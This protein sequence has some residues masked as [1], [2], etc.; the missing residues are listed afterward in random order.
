MRRI[1]TITVAATALIAVC[2]TSTASAVDVG[3][4]STSCVSGKICFFGGGVGTDPSAST[5]TADENFTDNG[6]Y[7]SGTTFVRSVN[8]GGQ[9]WKNNFTGST[10]VRVYTAANYA[11]GASACIGSGTSVGPYPVGAPGGYSSMRGGAPAGC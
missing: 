3:N 9:T 10:K 2:V 1:L 6:M 8:D 7:N 5:S 11:S 4:W